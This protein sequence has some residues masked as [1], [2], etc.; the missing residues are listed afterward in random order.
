MPGR[1]LKLHEDIN[2]G[3]RRDPQHPDPEAEARHDTRDE[4]GPPDR[5]ARPTAK[6]SRPHTAAKDQTHES[7]GHA[8]VRSLKVLA[9]PGRETEGEEQQER[10]GQHV[11]PVRAAGARLVT[12]PRDRALS[13]AGPG[14]SKRFC[15]KDDQ[16]GEGREQEEMARCVYRPLPETRAPAIA[17]MANAPAAGPT[18]RRRRLTTGPLSCCAMTTRSV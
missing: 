2:H 15:S 6:E 13:G 3:R 5:R 7:Q 4:D 1:F 12:H 18:S 9:G 10:H 16:R 17:T 11:L 14:L 8:I